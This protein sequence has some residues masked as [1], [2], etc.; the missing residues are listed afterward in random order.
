MSRKKPPV[1]AIPLE[2]LEQVVLA[3]IAV[4][5]DAH[6][7]PVG[8]SFVVA[9]PEPKRALLLTA[10][11]N[12]DMVCQLDMPRARHH[13]S[14][15]AEFLP[16]QQEWTNLANTRLYALLPRPTGDS[17]LVEM[18]QGWYSTSL[19]VAVLLVELKA[20]QKQSFSRWFALDTRPIESGTRVMAVGYN[21]M[22]PHFLEP[23][24]YE[25][26]TFRIEVGLNLQTRSGHVT[27]V[28]P[29]GAGI[30]RWPGFLVSFALDSGMSG[31]PVIDLSNEIPLVRG[32]IGG[33]VG[34][35]A[36]DGTRG[37]GIRPFVGMLWP[38]MIIKTHINLAQE[39]AASATATDATLLD[40]VRYGVVNDR[41]RAHEH[42]Q[43][44]QQG[45]KA[46]LRWN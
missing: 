34:E 3:L 41:G 39:G 35:D 33:D 1:D 23:P 27:E 6:W 28:C 18:L 8:S 29:Q 21:E 2:D 46:L 11:H 7:H 10:A 12:L 4:T 25:T 40:L 45:P 26:G 9:V 15:L 42:V 44:I 30:H 43:I 5:K 16:Q 37:S 14:A 20:E 19:D 24:N 31:G 13:S 36:E 22:N 32:L 38:S 17:T